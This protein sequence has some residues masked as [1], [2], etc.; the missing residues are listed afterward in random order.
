M[1]I[2]D[3]EVLPSKYKT[4]YLI[5]VNF[6]L[7]T[8]I[9]LLPTPNEPEISSLISPSV[10]NIPELSFEYNNLIFVN[11]VLLGSATVRDAFKTE[12]VNLFRPPQIIALLPELNAK[13]I[14]ELLNPNL[15]LTTCG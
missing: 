14:T 3:N 10:E 1:L 2:K 11:G 7:L 8:G 5:F 12:P 4:R 9:I 13:P 6:W 15:R